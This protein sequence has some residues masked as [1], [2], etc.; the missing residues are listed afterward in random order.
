MDGAQRDEGEI[1]EGRAGTER[2]ADLVG[3]GK[4]IAAHFI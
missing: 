3:F 4:A 2:V 1:D